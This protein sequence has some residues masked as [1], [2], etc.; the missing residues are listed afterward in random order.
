MRDEITVFQLR[1]KVK[2]MRPADTQIP[3]PWPDPDSC[4][5]SAWFK[6][7]TWWWVKY[8]RA[9]I[10]WGCLQLIRNKLG[11][12]S[13]SWPLMTLVHASAGQVPIFAEF[14]CSVCFMLSL[15]KW[16]KWWSY[17]TCGL[18]MHRVGGVK[19]WY[20]YRRLCGPKHASGYKRSGLKQRKVICYICLA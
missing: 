6:H 18:V 17:C 15:W 8:L 7:G 12:C 20:S 1:L 14:F 5:T 10:S 11:W 4:L 3:N 13:L 19:A 2:G 16:L 9:F